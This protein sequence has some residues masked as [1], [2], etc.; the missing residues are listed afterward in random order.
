[1]LRRTGAAI[2]GV[3]GGALVMSRE[4]D[5]MLYVNTD[6]VYS[7]SVETLCDLGPHGLAVW[8]AGGW[9]LEAAATYYLGVATAGAFA[10]CAVRDEFVEH[11]PDADRVE[12]TRAGKDP[13]GQY[14]DIDK[15]DIVV[16]P[17]T[18]D[19]EFVDLLSSVI[20]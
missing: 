13:D 11:F 8:T 18:E 20:A 19:N 10:G 4:A 14:N 16:V 1:M 2:S 3:G 15:G 7:E 9:A 5:A 12:V 17:E 6:T